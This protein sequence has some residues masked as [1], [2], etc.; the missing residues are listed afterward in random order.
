MRF[1]RLALLFLLALWLPVSLA[2][3]A[4]PGV[5][6][7]GTYKHEKKFMHSIGVHVISMDGQKPRRGGFFDSSPVRWQTGKHRFGLAVVV[8][9]GLFSG[10]GNARAEVVATLAPGR[11][12][13]AVGSND[14]K[15]VQVWIIDMGS[16]KRVSTIANVTDISWC[17]P[18][19]C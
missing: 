14:G 3:A 18:Q 9:S 4:G 5:T 13:K 19:W 1:A 11:K 2:L 17:N 15:K 12:Y 6:I 10:K 16:N 8:F 7:D